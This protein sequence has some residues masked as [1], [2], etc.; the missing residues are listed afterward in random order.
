M[1]KT[2]ERPKLR[3][4]RGAHPARAF[5]ITRTSK[6]EIS[7][8]AYSGEERVLKK[9]TMLRKLLDREEIILMPDAYDSLSAKVIEKTGFECC[10]TTGFGMSASI[11]GMPDAGFLTM[12]EVVEQARRMANAISIPLFVDS[13]TGYG[14]PMNVM[15]T[16]REFERA[17]AAGLFV[18]DQIEPKRCG[19]A[20]G[21]QLL[22]T[23]EMVQK[24][25]A[26]LDA[27]DDPDFVIVARTD[28]ELV[29]TEEAVKRGNAYAQ[30]GAD[31][32]LP[33]P[34]SW[35]DFDPKADPKAEY[36]TF[37]R[38]IKAQLWTG[39]CGPLETRGTLTVRDL[40]AINEKAK[41]NPGFRTVCIM[42]T[43]FAAAGAIKGIVEEFKRT[44]TPVEY[45]RKLKPPNREEFFEFVG[46]REY[47]ALEDKYMYSTRP[48]K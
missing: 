48:R 46:M 37:A 4:G 45:W 26:A 42:S 41:P 5:V 6:S 18:E 29:S 32:I 35:H 25:K 31:G 8:C 2:K 3:Q 36:E 11:L 20:P 1:R 44:G 9:T 12:T 34:H 21:K 13:D 14:N 16:V 22:P 7:K 33:L 15:R 24:I 10:G 19:S 43:V 23:E 17:G 38:K 40:Q 47:R 30:A 39:F 28:G 27:R